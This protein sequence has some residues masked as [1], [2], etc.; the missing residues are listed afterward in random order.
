MRKRITSLLLTLVMLLSLVPAMGVTASAA[1]PEWTTVSTFDELYTAVN[2]K[3]EYIKLGTNISTSSLNSGVG[4]LRK[5]ILI[6][7]GENTVLD[8]NGNT[9]NLNSRLDDVY[10]FIALEGGSLTIKDSSPAKNGKISG[11]FGSTAGGKLYRSITVGQ[12]GSLTL[13]GGTFSVNGSPYPSTTNTIYCGKGSVTVKDGVTISQPEFFDRGYA[14]NLDGDGYALITEGRSKAIIEGGTFDG[15]VKLT[16]YQDTNGS[17]QINGGTFKNVV[18]LMY[19]ATEDNPNPAVIVNDGT[20]ENNVYLQG[21]PWRTSLYMPHRLNGGTIYGSLDLCADDYITDKDK[22]EGNLNIAFGL[23][24]CFGYNAVSKHDGVFTGSNIHNAIDWKTIK[25]EHRTDYYMVLKGDKSNPIRIIPNAWGMKSV[26][27]DGKSIN[28]A[29]DWKGAV[30]NL[31]NDNAHTLKFE[32]NPLASEL[33]NAG[34]TY[35]A[36]FDGYTVG[37]NTPTTSVPI[38]AT[39]TEYSHTIPADAAP[40]VYPFDL[41]LNLDKNGSSVGIMSNQHIVKLVVN[42]AP[43]VLDTFI[44]TVSFRLAKTVVGEPGELS[45]TATDVNGNP[46]A[47]NP[48]VTW[49]PTNIQEGPNNHVSFTIHAPKGYTFSGKDGKTTALKFGGVDVIGYVDNT[50]ALNFSFPLDV[51]HQHKVDHVGYNARFHWDVCSCGQQIM[52]TGA[53][54]TMGD[55]VA[56]DTLSGGGVE[57]TRSCTYAGCGYK[58]TTIDYSGVKHVTSL[59]LNMENYPMDGMRPH[60]FVKNGSETPKDSDGEY[61]LTERDD[62]ILYPSF[63]ITSGGDKAKLYAMNP[64]SYTVRADNPDF[65]KWSSRGSLLAPECDDAG[66]DTHSDKSTFTTGVKYGVRLFLEAENGY[67]FYKDFNEA[68][69]FKLFTDMNGIE[70]E[71]YRVEAWYYKNIEGVD[72]WNRNAPADD[73]AGA[74][75]VRVLFQLTA[76]NEGDLNIT[77]PELKAGDDLKATWAGFD[78][79]PNFGTG[80]FV[81]SCYA[82]NSKTM[83]WTG[84]PSCVILNNSVTGESV[85]AQAGQTYTLTIPAVNE[86]V[87]AH[88]TIKNP[89]AATKVIENEDGTITVTYELP[90]AADDKT[91]NGAAVSITPPAY[92]AASSTT[93]TVAGTDHCTASAVT[94]N[95]ADAAFEAKEYTATVTLTAN[96]GYTFAID[97]V[98][99]INGYMATVT[100]NADGSVTL[101][102]TFPALTGPHT[103]TYGGSWF[104]ATPDTHIRYCTANDGSYEEAPHSITSWTAN[105]DGKTH[106]GTCTDCHYAKTENHSWEV[107]GEVPPTVD[108]EGSRSYKCSAC[109]ATKNESI[110]KLIEYSVT[111]KGDGNGTASASPA[112]AVAGTEITLSAKADSGYH[113]KEWQVVKGGMTITNNKFTMP[114]ENVEVKAIFEKNTSTGGGGGGGGVTTYPITVK[115]A[116]N[117]DVTASHKTA[118]KGTAVTLTVDPDKGYVLDTLT[119]LDGK[120]KEIKLTEKN[121]KYTFTM[122]ASKVTVE[123]TFKAAGNNPFTDVPAG[124]YYEDAVI[125]AVDKGITTGTSATTFNPNGICTRAQAVTFLWRAAG[126]PAAKSSAMPFADVKA[127]SYYYDAVLWAVEQGITKGTS[128]TMFSPDATCTRAQIVTFLWRANGSPVVSGNSAFTDVASDAYYAAAVAWAEKNDVTGGIGN[129]LFGSNNNCTRAQIV[130]FLYRA[131]K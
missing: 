87:L 116:K 10:F 16:G 37:T 9:L 2:D 119:V 99:T 122:P 118:S 117:G 60:N 8:L 48:D 32:W 95:P 131:M 39:A 33:V 82:K 103:H 98:F 97:A 21:W 42:P 73:S 35:R 58:E 29:K 120:D 54:H 38:S 96:D 93:A 83:Q 3:K 102:Y 45:F 84:G 71:T 72:D 34:Y 94:W 36:N 89:E 19:A 55:W 125:W 88:I 69:N 13:E 47:I 7:K 109:A 17:V 30:E 70:V 51:P 79:T 100:K 67:A 121:G 127:G 107:V 49:D 50:G 92:G 56:G 23:E 62:S 68:S 12:N 31:T 114:A 112:K 74:S 76:K 91:V 128:D 129:G 43:P 66:H 61:L 52:N 80:N 20:F 105:P 14:W 115:S 64:E 111:A 57:Y 104:F 41:Q 81:D 25:Q 65:A 106:T 130:T 108:M 5:D 44:S 24:K 26:T 53:P 78:G 90:A 59:V 113:F 4:M 11:S 110:P 18:Q 46:V 85:I 126:S 86:N 27:L 101:R 28:Y 1:E 123:A 40:S 77:L 22:P 6:F 63:S 124:S 15:S 75:K